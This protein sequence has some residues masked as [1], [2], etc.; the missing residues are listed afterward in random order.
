VQELDLSDNPLLEGAIH[1]ARSLRSNPQL[2]SI[3]LVDVVSKETELSLLPPP[4]LGMEDKLEDDEEAQKRKNQDKSRTA[5]GNALAEALGQSL[6]SNTSLTHIYLDNNGIES[7]A[8]AH[9]ANNLAKSSIVELNLKTNLIDDEGALLLAKAASTK[10]MDRLEMGENQ[11]SAKGF[12]AL[13]DTQLGY[14]GLF[15]NRVAG[16]GDDPSLLPDLLTSQINRLDIGGNK[17][18]HQDVEAMVQVLL[19][20]GVPNLKL[21]EMGGNVEDKEIE[22]WEHTL[23]RLL[24][25]RK[26]LEIIWKRKPTDMENAPPPTV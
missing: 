17:I 15:G 9:L 26:D 19:N 14:L 8:L 12:G 25:E 23:N 2:R 21:L 1:L 4:A 16:F 5:L 22:L 6:V 18:V 24:E 11:I 3:K 20:K 7:T 13:L 10:G